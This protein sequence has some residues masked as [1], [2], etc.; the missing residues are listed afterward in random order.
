MWG[1]IHLA[2]PLSQAAKLVHFSAI[3]QHAKLIHSDIV[4]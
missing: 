4:Q 2:Q 1:K 3:L